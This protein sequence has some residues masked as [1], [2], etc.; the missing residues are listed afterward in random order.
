MAAPIPSSRDAS[1]RRRLRWPGGSDGNRRLTAAVGAVL[2]VV[3]A[4][5][6]VTLAFLDR[7][8][9]V[10]VLLGIALI[11]LVVLKLASVSYRA[12]RYYAG[13]AP[14]RRAGPPR[15]VLRALAPL[16]VVSTA[17]LLATGVALAVAGPQAHGIHFLHQASFVVWLGATSLHVLG[18][19]RALPRLALAD[20]RR[21]QD[22]PGSL[23]RR[24]LPASV[25]LGGV[26]AGAAALALLPA[27]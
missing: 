12:A 7:L 23:W 27:W 8:E 6:G 18:H 22:V 3:L 1:H 25:L 21:R 4:A 13:A 15:L 2:V 10:H 5:E 17:A 11:P 19:L 14:Y 20:W 16:V 26:L 9:P 24:T